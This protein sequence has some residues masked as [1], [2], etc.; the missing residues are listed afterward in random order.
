MAGA[1]PLDTSVTGTEYLTL[2]QAFDYFNTN[3]FFE[4]FGNLLPPCLITYQRDRTHYGYFTPARFQHRREPHVRTDEIALNPDGFYG[5]S[6][7]E[8]LGTLVH[9]MTHLHQ[10]EY[11]KPGRGRYHNQEWAEM[12]ETIGLM[13]SATGQ[14]RGQKTG[15]RVSHYVLP[16]GLFNQ[17]VQELFKAGLAL[18]WQSGVATST[19]GQVVRRVSRNKTTFHCGHCGLRAWAKPTAQLICGACQ[20]HMQVS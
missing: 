6:D 5:R 4:A 19:G 17:V 3:L 14:P 7:K 9:E 1:R 10:H 15:E 18:H 11:G 20:R 12:M 13:P 16:S 8:I 2:Q